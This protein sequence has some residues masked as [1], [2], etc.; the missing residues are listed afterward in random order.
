M[1][2]LDQIELLGAQV[3]AGEIRYEDAVQQLAEW[4]DDALT[5]AG[6]H[7]WLQDWRKAR[8]WLTGTVDTANRAVD[9]LDASVNGATPQERL[10]A[11][12]AADQAIAEL[13]DRAAE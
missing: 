7:T 1:D 12:A 2:L 6:A 13:R 4:H 9:A 11:L 10:G 5:P 3:E 8:V